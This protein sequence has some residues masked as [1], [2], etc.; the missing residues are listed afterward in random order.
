MK[1]KRVLVF[2]KSL[3]ELIE[4]LDATLRLA[5]WDGSDA[6]PEPLRDS[7]SRLMARLGTTDRLA[8]GVFKGTAL[9]VARVT[10]L[11]EAMRRLETAYVSYRKKL[12]SVSGASVAAEE[13]AAALEQVRSDTTNQLSD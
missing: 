9:D 7:A 6:V 11:T 10:T 13:L 12:E 8:A 1:D 5:R 4:S 2:R 3:E